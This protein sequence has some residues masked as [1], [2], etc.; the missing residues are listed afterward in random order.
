MEDAVVIEETP[1]EPTA[2]PPPPEPKAKPEQDAAPEPRDAVETPT[3]D[4]AGATPEPPKDSAAPAAKPRG[5]AAALSGF[6]IGGVLAAAIGFVAARYVVPEGWPFP[7]V[8]PEEDPVALAVEAQGADIAALQQAMAGMSD[9][10][11]ALR[12][13]SG[14]DALRADLSAQIGGL[15]ETLTAADARLDEIETRLAAVERLAPEG[16]AAARMAAEAYER[17]LAALRKLFE[18]ELAQV[19]AAEGSAVELQAQAAEAAQA[20]AG[21]AALARVT[22]ALETGQPFAEALAD[23]AESTGTEAPAALAGFAETGV[24]TLAG[25]QES[26]PEAARAALDASV[27]AA[28][29]SGE[30]S[31]FSAFMR[32]QLGTRSLEAKEGDDADAVLSRAEAALRQGDLAVVLRELDALPAAGQPAM[33]AWRAEAET[34]RAAVDAGAALA[35]ELNAK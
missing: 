11:A 25:L 35:R 2:P 28:V 34:R 21:R 9:A 16:S 10:V 4:D 7:G 30:M 8:A 18:D 22:A 1:A 26:F 23:L 20:A 32:T 13:D 3:T 29:E 33:A 17:E 14:L 12:S 19:Q 24:P 27:R 15:N 6:V 31:R 5:G